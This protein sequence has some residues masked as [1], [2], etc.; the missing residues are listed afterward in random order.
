MSGVLDSGQNTLVSPEDI[1]EDVQLEAESSWLS[2]YI[3]DQ[4]IG[5]AN[6]VLKPLPQG[7]YEISEF[8]LI[9]GAMMGAQQSMRMWM[10]INADSALALVSFKGAVDAGAYSTS[11][12]GSV[13]KRV[14]SVKITTS[15]NPVERFFP[16]PEPIYLSQVVKPLIQ[17]GK[18]N[19]GDSLKLAGF[20]PVSMK[21]QDM[22]IVAGEKLKKEIDGEEIPVRKLTTTMEGLS[23]TLYV[24][25]D[26]NTVVE[27]G[28]MGMVMK[29]ESSE[30]ALIMNDR[31][32]D[33]DFLSLYSIKPI[34]SI[35]D[36]RSAA[37]MRYKVSGVSLEQVTS[38]SDRQKI[39]DDTD[40][41]IE[42]NIDSEPVQLTDKELTKFTSD[43]PLIE[44]RDK[45]IIY[46]AVLAVAGGQDR[47]DSLNRLSD[48]VFKNVKKKMS[49]GI[50]SALAVLTTREG[51]CNEHS[52]LF[53]AM[54]RAVGIPAKMQLGVVYQDGS[55]YYHA[56]T[57]AYVDKRWIEY[58]P[59]FGLERADAARIA[60]ASGD[61]SNAIELAGAIGQIEIEIID[62]VKTR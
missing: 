29:Q 36:P 41:L 18:F 16:A 35:R 2:I 45:Q 51:D 19:E 60:L 50:P 43:A 54:A 55:F 49:A 32:G 4:K 42:V 40:G 59:T 56:W 13:S 25:D 11:Y 44:C 39:I 58:E 24:D 37:I 9:E 48:W 3:Q 27:Y 1:L 57:A 62:S 8:S 10:N 14:L 5:Y 6:S 34:G 28:P 31:I 7:G 15:G 61:L 30:K 17:S 33:V 12:E 23:S 21:M 38:A 20:D 52:T 26:G 22:F 46:A 53:V 47:L